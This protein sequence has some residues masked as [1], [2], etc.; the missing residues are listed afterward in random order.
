MGNPYRIRPIM[1]SEKL[2]QSVTVRKLVDSRAILVGDVVPERLP[3]V[4]DAVLALSSNFQV[5]LEF[6]LNDSKKS[7]IDV[8]INGNV[9]MQCQRCLNPVTLDVAIATTL[10]VAAHDEE[11]RAQIKDYEPILLN[12][13]GVLDIDSL[14]EEEILLNLPLV[15]MHPEATKDAESSNASQGESF[16]SVLANKPVQE[17]ERRSDMGMDNPFDVLKTLKAGDGQEQ[18]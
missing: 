15:A 14:I 18:M 10:T 13:E 6:G 7:K 5:E 4:V 8:Q 9:E 3:R 16:N 1:P 12:D 17:I 2:P 11:A